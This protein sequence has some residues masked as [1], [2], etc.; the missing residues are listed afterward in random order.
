M[1]EIKFDIQKI[2]T[3][4]LAAGAPH[5]KP[6]QDALQKLNEFKLNQAKK[7]KA[8]P[9]ES[10][11]RELWTKEENKEFDG[12]IKIGSEA[13]DKLEKS[14]IPIMQKHGLSMRL[15]LPENIKEIF[16]NDN[17]KSGITIIPT[18]TNGRE[19]ID[20]IMGD[21]ASQALKPR[22]MDPPKAFGPLG[23]PSKEQK[24]R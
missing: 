19:V 4:A 15:E 10:P 23:K 7:Y 8:K 18:K 3:E 11:S 2:K 9:G 20:Q 16:N 17:R 14:M 21:I 22:E 5:I 6:F 12:I 1:A 13:A 24:H